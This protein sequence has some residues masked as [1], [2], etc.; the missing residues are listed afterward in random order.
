MQRFAGEKLLAQYDAVL[1]K[2]VDLKP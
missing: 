2:L 1:E